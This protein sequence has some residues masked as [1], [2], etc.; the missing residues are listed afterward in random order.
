MTLSVH[1]LRYRALGQRPDFSG[2]LTG[3]PALVFAG[4]HDTVTSPERQRAFAATIEGS[5]F[6]MIGECD[7]WVVL[8]RPDDVADLVARFFTD[9]PLEP[10][11]G[12]AVPAPVGGREPGAG[13]VR[14]G[15]GRGPEPGVGE[16]RPHPHRTARGFRG[17]GGQCPPLPFA[18]TSTRTTCGSWSLAWSANSALMCT[19]S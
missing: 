19:T 9:R 3:V 2:G 15:S 8:E 17:P 14:G 12:P 5:R 18:L 1:G 11:P 4:E 16:V 7:H 13:G 10:A 6:L